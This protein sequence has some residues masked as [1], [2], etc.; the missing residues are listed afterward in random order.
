MDFLPPDDY[1]LDVLEDYL[2]SAELPDEA[3]LLSELDGY[4]T[5]V[6]IAPNMIMPSEWLSEIWGGGD[7]MFADE[8]EANTILGAIM[9]HYNSILRT[10]AVDAMSFAPIFATE[11][12]GSPFVDLWA[13]GFMR[14]VRLRP[15]DWMPLFEDKLAPLITAIGALC[16]NPDGT[17]PIEM[18]EERRDLLRTQAP[19][20]FP[21]C[22]AGIREYWQGRGLGPRAA[23]PSRA[24]AGAPR[25][26][27]A[28]I[29]RNA[30]CSCGSGK[31]YKRC[32]G[33]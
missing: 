32:C 6:A 30:P 23:P 1:D 21:G 3:M 13:E 15:K 9:G 10:L 26:P 4:L 27:I 20:L 25:A 31:K 8:K 12:D 33:A 29:G 17:Y 28:K 16:A 18:A 11:A 7:P 22:V 24:N 19:T 2:R 14:G 5:A